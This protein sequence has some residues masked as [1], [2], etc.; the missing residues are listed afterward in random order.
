M[1]IKQ[2]SLMVA[3]VGLLSFQVQQ[4]TYSSRSI[5]HFILKS[6]NSRN[7][8][9]WRRGDKL[10]T[11]VSLVIAG[12]NTTRALSR[13]SIC[14][15]FSMEDKYLKKVNFQLIECG[16]GSRFDLNYLHMANQT[17]DHVLHADRNLCAQSTKKI[18]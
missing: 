6:H 1:I 7:S 12:T 18:K 5:L 13:S 14:K 2:G 3:R 11:Y 8:Y 9:F 10:S 4:V 15:P 16:K 17:S